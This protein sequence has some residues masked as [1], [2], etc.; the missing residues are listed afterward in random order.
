MLDEL[1][2]GGTPW[3]AGYAW[4]AELGGWWRE[5]EGIASLCNPPEWDKYIPTEPAKKFNWLLVIAA[6]VIIVLL[7]ALRRK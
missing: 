2:I 6:I 3:S 5:W 4:N 1:L 7:V